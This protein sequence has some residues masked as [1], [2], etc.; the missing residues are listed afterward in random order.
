MTD[1]AQIIVVCPFCKNQAELVDSAEIYGGRSYGMAWLC[2]PC[3]AYVGCHKNSPVH[4]PLGTLANAGLRKLR[5][6]VHAVLDPIWKGEIGKPHGRRARSAVYAWLARQLEI[7]TDECHVAM[8]DSVRAA[9][10][11]E[12]LKTA[13]WPAIDSGRTVG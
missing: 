8:F 2:R 9:K 6:Q 13:T 1:E 7:S 5:T 3:W 10:A 4:K 11:L 12:I